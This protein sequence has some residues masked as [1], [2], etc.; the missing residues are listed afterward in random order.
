M[1]G[2]TELEVT[3]DIL[4]VCILDSNSDIPVWAISSTFYSITRTHEELSIVCIEDAVPCS[5]KSEKGWR[6]IKVQGVLDFSLV[7][8]LSS[9]ADPLAKAGISI[10]ALSTYN[11]D[12]ILVKQ[13]VLANA[14][15]V[16]EARGFKVNSK[17]I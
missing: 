11:T 7:G 17:N 8:I 1:H 3:K 2:L 5:V 14:V 6:S 4:A 10:F 15:K 12:Y 13:N 16:L 9:I